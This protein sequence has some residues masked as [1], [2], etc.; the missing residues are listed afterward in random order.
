[1]HTPIYPNHSH[2]LLRTPRA[3]TVVQRSHHLEHPLRRL[4]LTWTHEDNLTHR[5]TEIKLSPNL[6]PPPEVL[7]T[8]TQLP[9]RTL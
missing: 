6:V 9:R 4:S 1:M 5:V 2:S 8:Q 3:L 7:L